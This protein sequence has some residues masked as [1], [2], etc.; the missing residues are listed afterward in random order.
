MEIRDD[1]Y[2]QFL[3]EMEKWKQKQEKKKE[4]FENSLLYN[5]CLMCKNKVNKI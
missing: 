2:K 4:K 3:I 1:E 5:I